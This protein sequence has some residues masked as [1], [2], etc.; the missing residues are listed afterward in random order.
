MVSM[1]VYRSVSRDVRPLIFYLFM[2]NANV[3][4]LQISRYNAIDL[5]VC[6]LPLL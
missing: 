1:I 4:P 6:T 2:S 5:S 3:P